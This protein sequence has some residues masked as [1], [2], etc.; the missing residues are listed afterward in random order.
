MRFGRWSGTGGCRVQSMPG[1]YVNFTL[2][3]IVEAQFLLLQTQILTSAKATVAIA[4][5]SLEELP[6]DLREAALR[7]AGE[8][9]LAVLP[10]SNAFHDPLRRWLEDVAIPSLRNDG[11]LRLVPSLPDEPSK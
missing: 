2:R 1:T 4:G 9:F 6:P 3:D 8:P 5:K 10:T 7:H 11:H